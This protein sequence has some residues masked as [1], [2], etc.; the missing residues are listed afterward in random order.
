MNM[1]F[2]ENET[3]IAELI[4][5]FI[6]KEFNEAMSKSMKQYLQE[7]YNRTGADLIDCIANHVIKE[8]IVAK[9]T[10][11][12]HVDTPMFPISSESN[13]HAE[14]IVL[15]IPNNEEDIRAAAV[16]YKAGRGK[17]MG[18]SEN[19]LTDRIFM[20]QFF[21]GI[22]MYAYKD[23][24]ELERV[25]YDNI[26]TP[27]LHMFECEGKNWKELPSPIPASYETAYYTRVEQNKV[28]RILKLYSDAVE[29]GI[30]KE[31]VEAKSAQLYRSEAIDLA[32]VLGSVLSSD[33]VNELNKI[34]G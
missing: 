31:D 15:S 11:V 20:L 21:S 5:N 1:W 4:S 25:Y 23:L 6:R 26:N 28:N 13:N 10:P 27:G 29:A 32:V 16:K 22:P 9:G 30:I 24:I 17:P 8:G 33:A 18:I 2:D 14:Y 7:K 3:K 19:V 12:F 34:Y